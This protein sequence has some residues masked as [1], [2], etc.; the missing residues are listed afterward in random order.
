M[1][2][3]ALWSRYPRYASPS[4][5]ATLIRG[6]GHYRVYC[7]MRKVEIDDK[8]RVFDHFFKIDEATLRFEKFDGQMSPTVRRLIFERGDSVSA[9]ILNTTSQR[10]VFLNQFRYPTYDKGPGWIIETVA[11]MIDQ[12]ETAETAMRREILEEIGYRV[13]SIEPISTFYLSP[14]GSSERIIL[15]Y[16]EIE[17]SGRVEAGGGLTEE[18]ED[19]QTLEI[20]LEEAL[21]QIATGKIVDAKTILSIYW[22]KTRL[23]SRS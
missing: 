8:R 10:L 23:L 22:Y 18:G 1:C 14:G 13:S 2:A 21:A 11:G 20:G 7:H 9:L 12:N 17:H 19:I 5:G 6:L 3:A 16:A 4:V 15:F